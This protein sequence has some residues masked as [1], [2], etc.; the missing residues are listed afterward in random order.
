MTIQNGTVNGPFAN[1]RS[2][3]AQS[4]G[5]ESRGGSSASGG[6]SNDLVSLSNASSLVS[7][8]KGMMPADKQAQFEAIS[9]QFR[10][11]QYQADAPGVSQAVVE[12][13]LQG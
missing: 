3:A 4:P 2:E 1:T 7:L 11:G 6:A 5:V 8:A 12:G 13:H 10:S 9:A